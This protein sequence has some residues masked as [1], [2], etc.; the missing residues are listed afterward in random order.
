MNYSVDNA[1]QLCYWTTGTATDG[2]TA[3]PTT[4]GGAHGYSYDADGN[5]TTAGVTSVF[6]YSNFNQ[7]ASDTMSGSTSNYTY[8]D[9]GS[10]NLTVSGNTTLLNGL[11]GTTATTTSAG[12]TYFTRDPSDTLI[13]M[14]TSAG[15]S[16]YTLD[17]QGSVVALTN[18]TP[19]NTALYSYGPYGTVTESGSQDAV[20]P[21]LY[22][23]GYK[24]PTSGL[25][26]FG[27]RY[28][29]SGLGDWTQQDPLDQINNVS[30]ANRYAYAGDDPTNNADPT[31][32]FSF[33]IS[34]CVGF[35][36]SVCGSVNFDPNSGISGS[37]G[38]GIGIGGEV[39]GTVGTSSGSGGSLTLGGCT[40][41][42]L[43]GSFGIA[44]GSDVL[45][46]GFCEG[47]GAFLVGSYTTPSVG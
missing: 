10:S 5:Q 16:Y 12:T 34:G 18:S 42:G 47:S 36:I 26:K 2:T 3:C 41:D 13:S 9:V 6:S 43:G 33:S 29:N 46:G 40:G 21:Y 37:I 24:D 22:A 23:G 4:P 38:G 44:G 1:N 28:Y 14:R 45:N 35:V 8:A 25:L 30:Q 7:L 20:N 27:Q 15:S 32:D 11:L 39:S 19:T 17:R 31:G